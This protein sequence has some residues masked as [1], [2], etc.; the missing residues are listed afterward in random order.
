MEDVYPVRLVVNRQDG[1]YRARWIEEGGQESEPFN[2]DLPLTVA[3]AANLR[4][5]LEDY[6]DFV[7]AGTRVRAQ[8]VEAKIDTWGRQLFE[9][10]FG[11]AEGTHVYRNLL[12]ASKDGRPVLLTLGSDQSQFLQQPWELMRDRRGPLAFQGVSIRRQLIG[13][14][15][16]A[17]RSLQF[18][19]PLRLLLIVARPSKA[20][21][22][23]P[24]SSMAP[25]LDALDLLPE[26]A[27]ELEFCQP[28]T[29]SR[30]EELISTARKEKRPFH[31]VH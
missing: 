16:G 4:W 29:L 6:Y 1:G 17:A 2:L 13:A 27:V 23:D 28:P 9:A 21:F 10:C 20:G 19:F 5:Y 12:E 31:I 18:K 15:P 3:D 8:G 24:R 14:K 11:T 25:L 22:I 26:G 30:L 7:G